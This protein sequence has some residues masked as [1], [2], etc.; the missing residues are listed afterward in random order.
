[1]WMKIKNSFFAEE[2]RRSPA[3]LERA[4][5]CEG[6]VVEGVAVWAATPSLY[7]LHGAHK[8]VRRPGFESGPDAWVVERMPHLFSFGGFH[9]ILFSRPEI[10]VA[11]KEGILPSE[12]F[13]DN[14]LNKKQGVLL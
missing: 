5:R 4:P 11:G 6:V 3:I 10:S 1:M 7:C 14:H 8:N 13:F 12:M 9:A 2:M